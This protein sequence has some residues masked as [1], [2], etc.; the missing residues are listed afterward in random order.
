LYVLVIDALDECNDEDD[1]RIILYLLAEVRSLERV[2][3]RVFLTSRP[4]IPIRYGFCQIPDQEYQDFVLHNISPSII[5]HD[6]TI[7]LEHSLKLIGQERSLGPSWPGKEVIRCLVQAAS[8][9]FIW[10]ATACRFI[11]EGKR[12]AARRLDTILKSGGSNS[13]V[14]APESTSTR[15]IPLSSYILSLPNTR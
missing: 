5:D 10:A 7:F 11:R 4:E 13:T 15:S 3:I 6:I 1:I 2:R 8:G 14:I 9:L 12:H